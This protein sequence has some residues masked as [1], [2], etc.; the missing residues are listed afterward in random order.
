MKKMLI[1]LALMVSG[2]TGFAQN[3]SD[4]MKIDLTNE[5]DSASYAYGVVIGNSLREQLGDN[6]NIEILIGA[7]IEV[8]EGKET[9]I[10]QAQAVGIFQAFNQ[11]AMARS[12]TEFL[13]KNK[14][15]EG[16]KVTSS[17]LQYEV[18]QKGPGGEKPKATDKVTVHYHGTLIDGT[19]FD[20]SVDR[21]TPASFGLN[22]VIK[23]WTEGL[24]LME[25]GDKFKFFI[26]YNL[27]YGERGAGA[28]IKPFSALVFEVELLSIEK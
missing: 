18:M 7:V 21:G 24:Q 4:K 26:P 9:Q 25:V 12:G 27:A 8:L 3:D 5:K 17:G 28:K 20:S 14:E 1:L 19:V 22:Q 11:K 16:V 13:E 10:E 6:Y 15:R 23:G 2:I